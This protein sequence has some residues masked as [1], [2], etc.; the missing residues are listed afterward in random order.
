M[1]E[2]TS[3]SGSSAD[4]VILAPPWRAPTHRN[5]TV[6]EFLC[7]KSITT[8]LYIILVSYYAQSICKKSHSATHKPLLQM[9][10]PPYSA[11]HPTILCYCLTWMFCR[12]WDSAGC[13]PVLKISHAHPAPSRTV[14]TYL[15]YVVYIVVD[16]EISRRA[17][18]ASAVSG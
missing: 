10:P 11:D 13:Y 18:D 5:A 9:S 7:S 16:P 8:A 6:C 15:P 3:S 1:T 4:G 12:V 2:L 14:K 17:A